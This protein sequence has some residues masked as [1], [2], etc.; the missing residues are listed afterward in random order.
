MSAV[1][2]LSRLTIIMGHLGGKDT[3]PMTLGILGTGYERQTR[4]GKA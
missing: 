2:F 1:F 4:A 3:S